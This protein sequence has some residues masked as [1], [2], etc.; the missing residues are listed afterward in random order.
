MLIST[1]YVRKSTPVVLTDAQIKALPTTGVDLVAAPGAGRMHIPVVVTLTSSI[2]AGYDN[3]DA[4]S[5][6][7]IVWG[8]S[9]IALIG[10]EEEGGAVSDLLT[11]IGSGWAA[12]GAV[13]ASSND[14]A[15]AEDQALAVRIV[16]GA[17]GDLTAGNAAN[18]VTVTVYYITVTL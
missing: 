4:A 5:S 9:I 14:I 18:T 12:G 7:R 1:S 10:M 3:I 15:D 8:A 16:N 17:A 6:I 11:D 13:A 2:V